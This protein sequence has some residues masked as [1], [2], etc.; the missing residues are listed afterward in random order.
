M[1]SSTDLPALTCHFFAYL[2]IIFYHTRQ[3]VRIY[4]RTFSKHKAYL[5]LHIVT[6]LTELA[7]YH[8]I[9]VRFNRENILPE[10]IDV[11]SCF[12]WGCTSVYLVKTLRR[13]DPLT[14]RPPYQTGAVLR[15][16]LS[17]TSYMLQSPDL[18]KVSIFALDS[19]LYA[20]LGIFFF[21]YTPYLRGYSTSTMYS[22]SIPL[23]AIIAIHESGVRGA[24][25]VFILA[26]AGVAKLNEWVS[27]RSRILEG[28]EPK[29][30]IE[31]LERQVIAALLYLG[32]A[33]L[34]RLREVAKDEALTKPL[35]DEYVP[36]VEAEIQAHL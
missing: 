23:S 6:G 27:Y 13:G 12:I 29:S 34:D 20:R 1:Y 31:L 16:V 24:S 32:F 5:Y 28:A 17:I 36:T 10:P 7:R 15:P 8:I 25:V 19:F 30:Y 2:A 4:S 35:T 18:H 9:K 14:T 26:M 11:L 3:Q 22:I 33:D 21:Y